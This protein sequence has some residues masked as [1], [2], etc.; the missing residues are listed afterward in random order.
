MVRLRNLWHPPI[1]NR[2][3]LFRTWLL[4]WTVRLGL[5]FLP[6]RKLCELGARLAQP[7]AGL[8]RPRWPAP[9]QIAWAV[10]VTSHFVPM[11]T[12]LTQAMTAQIL[13]G[14]YGH[15]ATLRIGVA[16]DEVDGFQAHA[17]V[18]SDGVVVIG[19]VKDEFKQK[20]VVL[21]AFE[22]EG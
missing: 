12:C 22:Q 3:F 19:G 4:V 17:W 7:P 20:Y 8:D 10:T 9:P 11:A 16:Q 2:G 21:P 6:F 14:R 15:P 1:L 13:L 5:W 18:E